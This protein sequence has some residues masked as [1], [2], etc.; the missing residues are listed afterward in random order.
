MF[1]KVFSCVQTK[2]LNARAG[3]VHVVLPLGLQSTVLR[4]LGMNKLLAVGRVDLPSK[5][6]LIGFRHTCAIKSM[7][8][9]EKKILKDPF[10]RSIC[11]CEFNQSDKPMTLVLFAL[12]DIKYVHYLLQCV[13]ILGSDRAHPVGFI[14]RGSSMRGWRPYLNV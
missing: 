5:C 2:S 7:R 11:A 6:A 8:P 12:L 14:M 13:S 9:E 3:Q 10:I 1:L 4:R